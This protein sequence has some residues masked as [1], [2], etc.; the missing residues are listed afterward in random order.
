[1]HAF[2]CV[3]CTWCSFRTQQLANCTAMHDQS[4][5]LP[6]WSCLSLHTA[7]STLGMHASQGTALHAKCC[8][9]C[10]C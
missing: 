8:Y 10:W 3:Y 6:Y 9:R 2:A 5:L 4:L 1:M 7:L